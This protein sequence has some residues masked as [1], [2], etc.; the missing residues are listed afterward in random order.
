[1]YSFDIFDFLALVYVFL[2]LF[3]AHRKFR[4]LKAKRVKND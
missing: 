1:M 2:A 3:I 4:L